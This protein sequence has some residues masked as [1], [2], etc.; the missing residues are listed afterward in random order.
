MFNQSK[1]YFL[2]IFLTV[3]FFMFNVGNSFA[4]ISKKYDAFKKQTTYISN[5]DDTLNTW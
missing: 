1:I 5:F 4:E 3:V 2:I